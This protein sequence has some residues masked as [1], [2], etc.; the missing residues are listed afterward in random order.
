MELRFDFAEDDTLTGFR[1]SSF[2]FYNWGTYHNTIN[3]LDLK[4]K[5]GLLTG[6]IGSGKSTIVDALTTLLVP[7][8]KII[9]NKAAGAGSKERSLRSYILGE[10]KSSKDENYSSSKAVSLRDE[11]SFSVLLGRFENDGYDESVTLAQFFYITNTKEHKFFIVSKGD[12]SIKKD[13]FD[14]K[15]VKE[16][17]KRLKLRAYTD[18][19][20]TFREYSK[21]FSR[22]MGLKNEQAINL[23]YQTVSLKEIGNLTSFIRLHMLEKGE[24]AQ[25]VD[26]LCKNFSDLN[27]AHE[28]VLRAKEQIELLT[29]IAKDGSR[30]EKELK[31]K[32]ETELTRE[33]LSEYFAK[34]ELTLIENKIEELK[35]EEIKSNSNKE[36]IDKELKELRA[37]DIALK[38]ELENN[39]GNRLNEI[40]GEI[41]RFTNDMQSK[42]KINKEYNDL[43]KS[44]DLAV[45]SN[46]HRFLKNIHETELRL[47]GVDGD[48][49]KVQNEKVRNLSSSQ[50]YKENLEELEVEIL[51]L[52]NNRSN[53]PQKISKIR[54]EIAKSLGI[55]SEELPFVGELVRVVD[56]R[57]EG[58][59]ERVL[60]SFA[61]SLLVKD[62][63]YDGV[64][65]YVDS[66]NLRGKLVYLKMI[67]NFK[68]EQY[69]DILPTSLLRKVEIKADSSL[70]EPL[71]MMLNDRFN[72]PCVETVD[73]FR[74]FKKAL[75]IH[76][77]FK[78]S[79][80]RHE[81]DD[82]FSISDKSQWLL[83]WD[84]LSKLKALQTQEQELKEK[85][86]FLD[87]KIKELHKDEKKLGQ[88]RDDLRDLLQYKEFSQIDWYTVSHKIENL[89]EERIELQES[90]DIIQT[91]QNE[92]E[93]LAQIIREKGLEAEKINKKIG[94]LEGK[95]EDYKSKQ[96]DLK[97][98]LS[99][100]ENLQEYEATIEILFREKIEEKSNLVNLKAQERH[101]RDE[102]N[103]KV[104]SLND[105]IK[106]VS[107]R[108]LQAMNVFV[109]KFPVM[110]KDFDA[111]LSSVEDFKRKLGELKKDD[112]P[113]W[114][115]RF[116]ELFKE[117]TLQNILLIQE[118][119]EYQSRATKE[120]IAK[121]NDSL[122]D[123]EYNDGTYV[124]L[125]AE[126]GVDIEIKEFRQSLKNATSGAIDGDNSYDE[127]KFLQIKKIIDRFNG[128][129]HY[130]DADKKWRLKVTDVRNW[131][132]FAASE[133][134]FSDESEKEYYAHSG[135]KSGGQKEKLAYTVLA[136][137]L[138]FQ[139]GIQH[140][141]IQSR[142]FR[143]VMIDEAFGK[144]SDESTKYALKL[145]EKLKL[146]LLV[147][148]PKTKINVIEP[149]VKSV[150]FVANPDGMN[151]S[152]LGMSIEEYQK[153]K[154]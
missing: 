99:R 69:V 119:L 111:S 60:H 4:Q 135:G 94:A 134:Y 24:I 31:H 46:E 16:L 9:Y 95:I 153:N 86:D 81:K 152:L 43:A 62:E 101:L 57:W 130:I 126:S 118:E 41:Q 50:K 15:D 32:N 70:F 30:Y 92:I 65:S 142:S 100:E 34:I 29:P 27:H 121:I 39:G 42:K 35:I 110:A 6:D 143:F 12:L 37:R 44:L 58:A 5:N 59:I 103:K 26:E 133:R 22:L 89:E 90:S 140:N 71:Q 131:F 151:S 56:E 98:L 49:A 138:A 124:A 154:K 102:L 63:Y 122:R 84:N 36:N 75:T 78:S 14:F 114:E 132:N 77:Q 123:I 150:H 106:R 1:L 127:Q 82:R 38:I 55:V 145:F 147:I 13:F 19:Y 48:L 93:K 105:S 79:L 85:R 129:E 17:K 67:K 117:K 73:E 11:G 104:K 7:H 20:D 141:Q 139:F 52:Q 80:S 88:L 10:Y 74:R 144:G 128:R 148:T 47:E 120:K 136:S 2:E 112:L 109:N 21:N 61:L 113:R 45:V 72:I 83:G 91:L 51:Y 66:T 137:S 25:K 116:K 64:S 146:Q 68:R 8:Q 54:D 96:V 3:S 87:K 33:V 115:K 40:E 108:L 125:I 18:V 149:F 107:E 28:S 53:I 97:A 76:G 23:F